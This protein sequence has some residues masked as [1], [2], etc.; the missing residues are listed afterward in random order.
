MIDH[1]QCCA[2]IVPK[3]SSPQGRLDEHSSGR[4]A[5]RPSLTFFP[6]ELASLGC[7]DENYGKASPVWIK[8]IIIFGH[9]NFPLV[10][11]HI[12]QAARMLHQAVNLAEVLEMTSAWSL[13]SYRQLLVLDSQFM[14]YPSPCSTVRRHVI[15]VAWRRCRRCDMREVHG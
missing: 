5:D 13:K 3:C 6:F 15:H 2:A 7:S 4:F 1:D 9:L 12:M 10:S 14:V 11:T 8:P